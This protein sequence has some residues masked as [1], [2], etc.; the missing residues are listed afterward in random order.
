MCCGNNQEQ[1]LHIA[2]LCLLWLF[3]FGINCF[4]DHSDLADII[5]TS[6]RAL[7][8]VCVLVVSSSRGRRK[9]RSVNQLVR[10]TEGIVM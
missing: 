9:A 4:K 10:H 5:T 8:F 3:F 6:D 1:L 7:L 2:S